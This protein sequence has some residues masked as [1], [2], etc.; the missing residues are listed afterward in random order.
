MKTLKIVVDLDGV[1]AEWNASA[2]AVLSTHCDMLPMFDGPTMWDWFVK[3]GATPEAQARLGAAMHTDEFWAK[4]APH[5]DMAAGATRTLL[6][7]LCVTHEVSFVTARPYGRTTTIDWL[8]DHFDIVPPQVILTPS[9]KVMALV[10][11]EPDVIIEDSARN[12]LDFAAAE[13]DYHL[14]KCEKILIS[15]PYNTVWHPSC[16]NASITIVT[17]TEDALALAMKVGNSE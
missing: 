9:R 1:V 4:L 2:H 5:A 11:M 6:A 13:R 10:A 16:R 12:L 17:S 14:P 15:R 7:D 3:Y 8:M